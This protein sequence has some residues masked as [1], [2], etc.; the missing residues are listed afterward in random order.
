MPVRCSNCGEELMGA[1]NRCWRCG[2]QFVAH[3]GPADVPPVR[4]AP[5]EGVVETEPGTS[6]E[7]IPAQL[8]EPPVRTTPPA[9]SPAAAAASTGNRFVD[10][11]AV[12]SLVVGLVSLI[13]AFFSPWMLPVS[14][15][16][17]ALG[18]LG[19]HSFRR[20]PALAGIVL[21]LIAV[22]ASGFRAAVSL[23]AWQFGYNPFDQTPVETI[24][25]PDDVPVEWEDW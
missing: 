6:D 14:F 11:A 15:A 25:S 19:L 5:V 17:V 2:R 24:D 23:Y 13:P 10:A 4:I 18:V 16:G 12:A 21:C 1:V 9:S 3:S 20:A 7:P 8:A 22:T